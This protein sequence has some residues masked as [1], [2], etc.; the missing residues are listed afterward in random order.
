VS[1]GTLRPHRH[2]PP[3]GWSAETFETVTSALASALVAAY[4][5]RS[6]R[7]SAEPAEALAHI[8]A[9]RSEL[10]TMSTDARDQIRMRQA[11]QRRPR[12]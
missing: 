9:R 10:A 7:G 5:R 2:E 3:D 8:T 1:F 6:E 11:P 4:R 12:P